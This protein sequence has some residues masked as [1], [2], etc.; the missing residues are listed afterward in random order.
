[1]DKENVIYNTVEYYAAFKKK[2]IVP[3]A[4]TWSVLEDILLSKIG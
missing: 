2:E 1:M 4:T 3:F